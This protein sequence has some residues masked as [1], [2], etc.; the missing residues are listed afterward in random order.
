MNK[1]PIRE[2][3]SDLFY[4]QLRTLHARLDAQFETR[5]GT[6]IDDRLGIQLYR[7]HRM[8]KE[9]INVKDL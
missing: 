6:Q 2:Q 8:Q 4:S 9:D 3:F 5:L 1:V 7:F